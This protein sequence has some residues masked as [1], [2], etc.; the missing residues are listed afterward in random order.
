[1]GNAHGKPLGNKYEHTGKTGRVELQKEFMTAT[2]GPGDDPD[3][4]IGYMESIVTEACG[5]EAQPTTSE[6]TLQT[7]ILSKLPSN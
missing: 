2:M 3:V 5:L 4:F 6:E 7:T 1:M